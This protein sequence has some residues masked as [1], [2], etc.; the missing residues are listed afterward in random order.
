MRNAEV[1]RQWQILREIESRRTGVT[2]HDLARLVK[3]TTRTIR[4]DLQAL[5]EAGFSIYDEG[6]ENE[7]KR[8]RLDAQPFRAVQE[9]LSV[10]DVA[11]LYLSRS[12]VNALSG[13]PLADELG[14]ALVKIE[15]AL[16]PRMR[17][18]LS[19]LPQVIS[20]KQAPHARRD[21]E[22]LVDVTRRLL[23]ATRDRRVVEMRYFSA[24]S[25][26]AKS[27]AVEP[28]RLTLAQGSVYLIAFVPAYDEFRTFAVDRI[29]RLS[30]TEKTFRR[31]R[32]LPADVFSSSL[33]VFSGPAEHV[34]LEFDARV[35]PYVTGR[36]WHESQQ[37]AEL[38]DGRVR[39]SLDVSNDW[40]LKSW[41]LGFGSAVRVVSPRDL[42][43]ALR[44]EL[45]RASRRYE[46]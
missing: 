35:A 43:D 7:T 27:Y 26:R 15:R 44:D 8:W 10:A 13:W 22:R 19:T 36:V 37:I 28:Y 38:A 30:V 20:T 12:I 32:D 1:I 5:Q 3:V 31:T 40:A 29:E 24:Q 16:N 33:G 23:D 46:S 42:V 14:T 2:I 6:E 34:E 11:A 4:R 25:R 18:F 21:S 39:V 9:G 17:E 41:I 45:T